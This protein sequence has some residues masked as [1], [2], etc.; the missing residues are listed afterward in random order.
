MAAKGKT[1]WGWI[2]IGVV[3]LVAVYSGLQTYLHPGLPKG[4]AM[5][6][7]RIE[8]TE[9]DIASKLAGRIADITAREG[10]FVHAGDIVAHMDT[11]NLQAQ[12]REAQAQLKQAEINIETAKMQVEQRQAEQEAANATVSQNEVQRDN[13]ERRLQRSLT[14]QQRGTVSAQVKDD[15]QASYDGAI[16]AVAAAKAQLA[17]SKAAVSASQANVVNAEAAVDAAKATIE[18]I[19]SDI[20]DSSLKATRSGR[21]QYRIAQ[22]GEVVSAGGRV[23]NLVDLGDVYMTFFLP[24][25]DVGKIAIGT[26]VRIVLDAAPQYVIPANIS[27]VSD[28]AQFTPKTVETAEERTKLMFRVRAQIPQNLLEKYIKQVKTG[29]PGVAYVKTDPSADWPAIV[30]N[31]VAQ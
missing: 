18:R 23:L 8:A 1:K 28:V 7:G 24:T 2:A 12:L 27:F 25:N 29:L 14:L 15:D 4:V 10:D 20:D 31:T 16:A 5:G 13:A 6:N 9:I 30:K 11:E 21:I 19:Q 3:A 22:P 17:A 26:E